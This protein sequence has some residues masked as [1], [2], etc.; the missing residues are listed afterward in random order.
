MEEEEEGSMAARVRSLFRRLHEMNYQTNAKKN[1]V[2]TNG[3]HDEHQ[4]ND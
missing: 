1:K 2:R 4:L 3:E